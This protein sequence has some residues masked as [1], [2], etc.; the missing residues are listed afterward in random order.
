MSILKSQDLTLNLSID[1]LDE[2]ERNDESKLILQLFIEVK[3][4]ITVKLKIV[5]TSRSETPVQRNFQRMPEIHYHQTEIHAPAKD[6]NG[7]VRFPTMFSY[8]YLPHCKAR[9]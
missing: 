8:T 5:L 9:R 4:L 7:M 2:C 3:D 1:A 6:R